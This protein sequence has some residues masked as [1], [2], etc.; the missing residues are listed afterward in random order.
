M[1]VRSDKVEA[2]IRRES[3]F[4]RGEWRGRTLGHRGHGM[5]LSFVVV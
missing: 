4:K 1:E 5:G 2:T 3:D